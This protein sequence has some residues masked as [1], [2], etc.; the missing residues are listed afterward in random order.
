MLDHIK[1]LA[2]EWCEANLDAPAVTE[3]VTIDQLDD[4]HRSEHDR[5]NTVRL[6]LNLPAQPGWDGTPFSFGIR[7]RAR[8]T[9]D[10][11]RPLTARGLGYDLGKLEQLARTSPQWQRVIENADNLLLAAR[12]EYDAAPRSMERWPEAAELQR[13]GLQHI[14]T[15]LHG[16]LRAYLRE[17]TFSLLTAG[18]SIHVIIDRLNGTIRQLAPRRPSTVRRW[19]LTEDEDEL[20]AVEFVGRYGELSIVPIEHTLI[21]S[22]RPFGNDLEGVPPIRTA[23]PWIVAKQ[24]IAQLW[25]ARIK[26][27]AMPVVG[28]ESGDVS[29]T[30]DDKLLVNLWDKFVADDYPVMTLKRGQKITTVDLHATPSEFESALRY[31]DEQILLPL[32]AEGALL[33]LNRMGAYSLADSKESAEIAQ[34]ISVVQRAVD[35]LNGVDRY[36]W[37]GLVKRV[38]DNALEGPYLADDYPSVRLAVGED[39]VPHADLLSVLDK[40]YLPVTQEIREHLASRLRVAP[41]PAE[42]AAEP[43]PEGSLAGVQVNAIRDIAQLVKAG[44]LD[45]DVAV[46][47]VK[48]GF[49]VTEEIARSMVG[50]L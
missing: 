1:P 33:G 36:P 3:L 30:S 37:T 47:I 24:M 45:V 26:K 32:S 2:D 25:H 28:I 20:L 35:T 6:S 16:G 49:G 7:T 23:A 21:S 9:P 48:Q 11:D 4:Q 5:A 14:L 19:I 46:A 40:G 27:Y 29:D 50:A 18:W 12:L 44:Q 8:D 43:V 10:Y 41:P 34:S 13:E 17:S 39:D 38:V 15:D 22:W 42:E 31:C